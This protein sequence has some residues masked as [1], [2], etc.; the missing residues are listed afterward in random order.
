MN[1]AFTLVEILVVVS[2]VV[3]ISAGLFSGLIFGER[4]TAASISKSDALAAA[5]LC[6]QRLDKFINLCDTIEYPVADSSADFAIVREKSGA[7][8]YVK[9]SEDKRKVLLSPVDEG[10]SLL[11]SD[12]KR[13]IL[14]FSQLQFANLYG[15]ELRMTL[16]FENVNKEK[17]IKGSLDFSRTYPVGQR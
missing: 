8:W 2:L 3:V 9:L 10:S 5:H 17:V 16:S 12:T 11:L 13:T 6:F 14:Q 15:K 4:T 7:R 1:K